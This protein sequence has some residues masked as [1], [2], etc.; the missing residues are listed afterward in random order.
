M[1]ASRPIQERGCLAVCR[2]RAPDDYNVIGDDGRVIG[3]I[4]KTAIPRTGTSWVWRVTDREART[5]A[6]S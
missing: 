4:F 5:R 6:K 2:R 3:R 1:D